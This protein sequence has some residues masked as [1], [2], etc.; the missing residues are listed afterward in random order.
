MED[1]QIN[2]DG[3]CFRIFHSTHVAKRH[4]RFPGFVYDAR[5]HHV[6]CTDLFHTASKI[7]PSR[8]DGGVESL[9]ARSHLGGASDI[10]LLG[11]QAALQSHTAVFRSHHR[12]ASCGLLWTRGG[13]EYGMSCREHV[14]LQMVL[15]RP[16]FLSP[17]H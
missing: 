9:L 13:V 4:D 16:K 1:C 14:G 7:F 10:F 12:L 17:P 5:D 6:S 11:E 2:E 8:A 3:C 15:I